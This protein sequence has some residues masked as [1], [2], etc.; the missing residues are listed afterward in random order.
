LIV[1]T[2]CSTQNQDGDEF[3]GGCG[4][5]LE[6]AGQK[7]DPAPE[8]PRPVMEPD[9]APPPE[10][11]VATEPVVASAPAPAPVPVPA[12]APAPAPDPPEPVRPAPPPPE[13]VQPA[14]VLPSRPAPKRPEPAAAAAEPALKP[15]EL[16]CPSCGAG[17]EPA[18]SF[19]RRCGNSLAPAAEEAKKPS[20]WRKLVTKDPKVHTAGERPM[21]D[22]KGKFKP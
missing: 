4:E 3:C 14:A 5:F 16:A 6:W 22:K 17:N 2:K 11:P 13:P 9:V 10:P 21:R 15:G 19:C 7:V 12:P 20:W 1:C 18:R 8:P